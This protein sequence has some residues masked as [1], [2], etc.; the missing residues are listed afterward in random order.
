M[1]S[2]LGVVMMLAA[3]SSLLALV[4]GARA[5]SRAL[6]R[7][8]DAI[9][10]SSLPMVS[11]GAAASASTEPAR[12][13]VWLRSLFTF[14]MRR[15]WGVSAN[16][17]Y[18]LAAGVV[19][20]AA[21]W[22]LGR[23]AHHLPAYVLATGAAGGFFLVPRFILVREQ[24]RSDAK[25]AELLPDA[26]DMV[27]RIVRAGLPVSAAIRT[28]GHEADPPLRNIFANIADQIE[29]GVPLDEAM[30]KT[31]E[32]VGNLDFRF[33]AVAVALQQ[34]TGGNLAATLEPLSQIIRGRRAVRLKA[35]AAIAE[36]KM[37]AIV[38]GAIPFFVVGA[39]LF[40]APRYLDPLFADPRGNVIL[41]LVLLCLLLAG[42][43]T[44]AMI[45]RSLRV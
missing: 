1:T 35:G 45:R 4:L 30:A 29:I 12:A 15:S 40:T 23:L 7:R 24:H 31:S 3:T 44:R 43:T 28:V 10:H 33:F 13:L 37:S 41:G 9:A 11:P 14:R 8:V 32:A 18:L 19:G 42:L 5:R 20:A 16:P 17:L 21:I 38:L 26:I 36:V 22:M 25:F 6:G 27:V 34:S 39:L 2:F